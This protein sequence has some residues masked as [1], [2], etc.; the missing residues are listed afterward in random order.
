MNIGLILLIL[1]FFSLLIGIPISV[2]MGLATLIALFM[3]DYNIQTLPLLLQEGAGSITLM[4]IPYFVLAGN[5]MNSAGMTSRIFDFAH[6]LVGFMKGGLSQV[7]V[8]ASMIFAGISGTSTADSAGL[9]LIE[10]QAMT[11]K[12]YSKP[13]SVAITL[14]S[15]T[16]GPIIPPSVG[17]IIYAILAEVSVAKMFIAGILPGILMGITL[18]IT[19]YFIITRGNVKAPEPEKFNFKA[20]FK[21]FKSGFFSLLAPVIIL[22]GILSGSV[23]ATETG[24]IAVIYALIIG[25]FSKCLTWEGFKKALKTTMFSVA[26]I[27]YM[28]GMGKAVGWLITMEQLPQMMAA[29]LMSLTTNKYIMLVLINILLLIL[30]MFLEGNT[31]KLIMVPLLL[32]IIDSI[33]MSRIQ[34]GVFQTLNALIGITTPPVGIGLFVMCSITDLNMQQVVKAF[35]PY[36]IPLLICLL[37]V[38][39]IPFLTTWLPSVIFP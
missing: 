33:G 3:G 6:A 17:F 27:I 19:N 12:G 16:I 25:I 31:I 1:F 8:L 9:G 11:E 2:S 38:T 20:L 32:P 10:I 30:G 15:S 23:T 24:I 26:L 35:L 39:Y 18:M 21:T 5:L 34:F 29:T 13:F 22:Y 37:L 7:N 36:Y 28:I 14:A 4:A